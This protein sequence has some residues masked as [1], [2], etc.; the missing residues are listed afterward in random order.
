MSKT[1]Q[2]RCERWRQL[3]G[4]QE[5][6]GLAVRAFC[7]QH[8]VS[9]PSFYQWRQRLAAQHPVKFALVETNRSASATAA[10]VEI[11][12]GGGERLRIAPGADAATLRL[13]LSVLREPR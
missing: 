9:E 12:L 1:Q 4:Q 2:E 8:R 11:I 7:E 5:R 10:G 3:I 13:A 6:S